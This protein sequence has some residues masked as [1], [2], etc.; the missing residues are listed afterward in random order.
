[1]LHKPIDIV[2]KNR[3]ESLHRTLSKEEIWC[4][5]GCC[6]RQGKKSD[7]ISGSEKCK[8][9]WINNGQGQHIPKPV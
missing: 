8:I 9:I 2:S 5:R 1:M 7:M 4:F 3:S 6:P